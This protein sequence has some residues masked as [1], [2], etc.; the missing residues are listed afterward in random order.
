MEFYLGD[1][2]KLYERTPLPLQE[3]IV[4]H[5]V[6]GAGKTTL[7]RS[8]LRRSPHLKAVT[9]GQPDPPTLEG[10]GILAPHSRADIVDEYPAVPDRTGAKVLLAD[11]LQHRGPILPAHF[12]G[13]RT[14]RFGKATCELL[15]LF[16]INCTADR[17]DKVSRSGLFD[18]DLVGTIIAVDDDAAELLE[19]H[20]AQFLTP[21]QALG[22][23]F[24]SVTAVSTV[25]LEEADPVNRYIACS[26]HSQQLLILEG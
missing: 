16:S 11:P 20:S 26:R 6:A 12:I 25:P 3:P 21:C 23:T 4:V 2:H 7:V 10:V 5:T 15:K 24:E 8:W 9:G 13:R 18:S 19:A 1:L 17:V 14:H 22:L